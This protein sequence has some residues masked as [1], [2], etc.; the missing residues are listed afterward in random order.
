MTIVKRVDNLACTATIAHDG[1]SF[2]YSTQVTDFLV[3]GGAL[4]TCT[5][6]SF[7]NAPYDITHDGGQFIIHDV[8]VNTWSQGDCQGD[9]SGSISGGVVTIDGVLS[10][11]TPNTG[12]CTIQGLL[13]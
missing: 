11:V 10:E 3:T 9:L 13:S 7:E 6:V 5:L 1:V 2:D 4:S 12:D 8:Y